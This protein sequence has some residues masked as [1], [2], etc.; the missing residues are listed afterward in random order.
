MKAVVIA[1]AA[2]FL[3]ACLTLFEPDAMARDSWTPPTNFHVYS[4]DQDV[5]VEWATIHLGGG[6]IA[7]SNQYG[8]AD[9]AVFTIGQ[10]HWYYTLFEAGLF[11]GYGGFGFGQRI[12]GQAAIG[13]GWVVRAGLKAGWFM[14]QEY[15]GCFNS[16]SA[17]EL[18]PHVQF[19]HFLK[20]A[21]VGIGLDVPAIV[22][23]R[24]VGGTNC[25]CDDPR[26]ATG[27]VQLYFRASFF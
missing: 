22:S 2:A 13:N 14:W 12:G 6:Y 16:H 15:D 17:V 27:G 25:M 24:V 4:T 10:A 8:K 23:G 11:M 21:S 7:F 9:V 19:V 1:A 26:K 5:L 18:A 3:I 20:H